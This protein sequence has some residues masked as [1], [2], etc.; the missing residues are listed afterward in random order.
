VWR[1]ITELVSSAAAESKKGKAAMNH[2]TPALWP[3]T[4]DWHDI[5]LATPAENLA[6]DEVLLH[7]VDEDPSRAILRTWEPTSHFVVVGRSN[8]VG[9]EV[10]VEQC[11]IEATPIFRRSSG[12]GAVVVGPGC[13]AY[14]LV[15]P[16]TDP[17]RAVGVSGVTRLV[18][19]T[20]ASGLQPVIPNVTVCGTSDLVVGDRKFSGNSQRWLKRAFLHH[21]TILCGFD[22]PRIGRLLLQPTRQPDYRVGRTH[23]DFVTNVT[24]PRDVVLSLLVTAWNGLSARCPAEQM[25]EAYS[26][27]QSRYESDDWNRER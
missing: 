17:L 25:T 15:L 8:Q 13:L 12:G 24:V 4:V 18:M 6:L 2:R 21:G 7:L 5:T 16:L 26:L 3:A 14:A 23:T 27:A 9:T 10:N 20:I 19:E 11:R 1:L 22:L